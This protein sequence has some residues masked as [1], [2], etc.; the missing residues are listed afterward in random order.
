V[1][2]PLGVD[3]P[4]ACYY[5]GSFFVEQGIRVRAGTNPAPTIIPVLTRV[6]A[7]FIPACKE[8]S[9]VAAQFVTCPK[10]IPDKL[11]VTFG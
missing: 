1:D 3:H 2:G 10:Y 11:M 4:K 6:G 7:R 9:H 8:F 5:F